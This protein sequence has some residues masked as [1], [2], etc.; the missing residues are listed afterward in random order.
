M[1]FTR[2]GKTGFQNWEM[3]L[4]GGWKETKDAEKNISFRGLVA[5]ILSFLKQFLFLEYSCRRC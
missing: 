5:V 3:K 2:V 4:D 1:P